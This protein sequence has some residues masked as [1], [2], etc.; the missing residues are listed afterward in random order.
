MINEWLEAN[1]EDIKQWAKN[2]AQ[3]HTDWEDLAQY[4]IITFLE[5]PKAEEL[6]RNNQAQWFIV[7]ILLNSSRGRKSEY[8]RLYRPD[9]QEFTMDL[10]QADEEYDRNIDLITEWVNGILDDLLHGDQE[11][12][13]RGTIFKLCMDQPK[14]NF[15]EIARNTGIPRTSVANAYYECVEYVKN[16]LLQYGATYDDIGSCIRDITGAAD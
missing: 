11:E 3:Q 15:S 9:Y 8:Y 6:V 16:K 13:F 12:W 4:A 1:Y 2:A 14:P 7:R 5:N 10:E